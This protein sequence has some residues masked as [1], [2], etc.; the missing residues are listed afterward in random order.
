MD[1]D[2]HPEG[3][4]MNIVTGAIAP[5]NINIDMAVTLGKKQLETFANSWPEGFYS[6]VKKQ[7]VTFSA[8][9]KVIKV[10]DTKVV[11]QEAIYARVIGLTASQ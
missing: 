5:S 1:P 6:T 2:S 11:D 3:A 10:A 9:R 8:T 7:I 4:L